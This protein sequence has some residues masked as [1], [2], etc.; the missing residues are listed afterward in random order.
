MKGIGVWDDLEVAGVIVLALYEGLKPGPD[1]RFPQPS[2]GL[3]IKPELEKYDQ[4]EL[5][6]S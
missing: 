6:Y 5:T 2:L 3:G 4:L 1:P